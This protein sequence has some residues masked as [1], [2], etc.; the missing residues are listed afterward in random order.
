MGVVR[1]LS[2][3]LKGNPELSAPDFA[4][5]LLGKSLYPEDG[6]D[7]ID[8]TKADELAA[9]SAFLEK[10]IEVHPKLYSEF[11]KDDENLKKRL[12]KRCLEREQDEPAADYL[13]RAYRDYLDRQFE[14]MRRFREGI[15]RR[16]VGLSASLSASGLD[17]LIASTSASRRIKDIIQESV[18][19]DRISGHGTG[20]LTFQPERSDTSPPFAPN[21]IYETNATL[22]KVAASIDEMRD[23]F[24]QQAEMQSNLNTVATEILNNFVIG[25][26]DAAKSSKRALWIAMIAIAASILP[27]FYSV[28]FD[29]K[30]QAMLNKHAEI[31]EAMKVVREDA[32][33]NALIDQEQHKQLTNVLKKLEPKLQSPVPKPK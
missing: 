28:I 6:E 29:N 33:N 18:G 8:E 9:N 10:V 2:G 32:R 15:Q 24:E 7:L 26:K 4:R 13:F 31:V 19:R 1:D 30:D 23:L 20:A 16:F 22:A 12:P 14:Q 25:A 21:P 3:E 17:S 11:V 5:L 27:F